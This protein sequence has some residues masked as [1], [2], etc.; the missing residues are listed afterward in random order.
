MSSGN[1]NK[2]AMCV[3]VNVFGCDYDRREAGVL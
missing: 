2:C 3:C 1:T